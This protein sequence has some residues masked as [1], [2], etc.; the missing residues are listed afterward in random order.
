MP[1]FKAAKVD[2]KASI[3]SDVHHS[4]EKTPVC[5]TGECDDD[6]DEYTLPSKTQLVDIPF[7]PI[8]IVSKKIS[9]FDFINS[10]RRPPKA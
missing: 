7:S 6:C 1:T 10:L 3:L 8:R 5:E 2:K 9:F 4:K